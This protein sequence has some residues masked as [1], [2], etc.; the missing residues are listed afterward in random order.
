MKFSGERKQRGDNTDMK[1]LLQLEA[2]LQLDQECLRTAGADSKKVKG[3]QRHKTQPV[4]KPAYPT[5][6][7]R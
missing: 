5:K 3:C 2:Q 1:R 7:M 6:A 4:D